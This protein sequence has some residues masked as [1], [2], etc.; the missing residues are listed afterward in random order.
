MSTRPATGGLHHVT[1]VTGDPQRTVDFYVET[2]GLRLVKRTVNHDDTDTYHLY[3]G[4]GTGTPG[5]G[6]TVFPWGGDGR[7]G[8]VGTS[9][10][11]ATAFAVPPDALDYWADR[12][13]SAGVAVERGQRFDERYLAFED[14]DGVPV[15]LV[16][17]DTDYGTRW[18]GSP[19]PAARQLRRLHGVTLALRAAETTADLLADMGLSAVGEADGRRRFLADGPYGPVVDLTTPDTDPG[20]GGVGTVHHVAFVADSVEEHAHWQTLAQQYG[21]RVT[22]VIDRTYFRSVYFRTDGGVLFEMATPT[23]GF[24]ADESVADLGSGL[25]LPDWLEDQRESIAAGLPT[26]RDPTAADTG[27]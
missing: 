11:T 19:V 25:A 13:E 15:E 12:L 9:Q 23:P 26:V 18:E 4:D 8:R 27:D 3:F 10:V 21:F 22:D 2:L 6:F 14:P 1:A 7:E 24:T 17:V 16:G 20:I 5:T